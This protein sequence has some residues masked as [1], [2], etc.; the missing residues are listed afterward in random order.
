MGA[1]VKI[2]DLARQ[3]IRL[4]GLRPEQDVAI[5]FTGLRPGEKL[6]EELFHGSE[7]PV[8]TAFEGLLM[9]SP[10]VTDVRLV[11]AAIRDIEAAASAGAAAEGV[12]ILA[13]MVPEFALQDGLA[14]SAAA[15]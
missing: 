6:F 8:P 2:V 13:R 1:P 12:A 15:G 14:V 3:M 7:K 9:A 4:A 11:A 10:R 5:R